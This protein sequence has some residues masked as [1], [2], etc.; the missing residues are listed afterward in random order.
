[1][2]TVQ[3]ELAFHTYQMVSPSTSGDTHDSYTSFWEVSSAN[4]LSNVNVFS[5]PNSICLLSARTHRELPSW[6][7]ESNMGRILTPTRNIQKSLMKHLFRKNNHKL[8]SKVLPFTD[9]SFNSSSILDKQHNCFNTLKSRLTLQSA[10]KAHSR[11]LN[12]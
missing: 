5:V 1:M 9:V 7:S 3:E 11:L 6:T 12:N 4:T 2:K 10:S 8:P